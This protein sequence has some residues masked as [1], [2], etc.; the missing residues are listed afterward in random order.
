MATQH[1]A[2]ALGE[3]VREVHQSGP[4]AGG[5]GQH[6]ALGSGGRHSSVSRDLKHKEL[7]SDGIVLRDSRDSRGV[8][9]RSPVVLDVVLHV[10]EAHTS[11]QRH[12]VGARLHRGAPVHG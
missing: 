8:W 2:E 6:Q 5:A 9:L 12:V 3:G 1:Q 11:G 4:T 10:V 7:Q